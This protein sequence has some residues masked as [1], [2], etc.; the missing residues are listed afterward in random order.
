MFWNKKVRRQ[1]A[2]FYASIIRRDSLC[3][4]IGANIGDR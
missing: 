3:F 4:D 2:E 1:R